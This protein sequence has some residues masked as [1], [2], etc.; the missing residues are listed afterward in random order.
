MGRKDILVSTENDKGK[1]ALHVRTALES[2]GYPKWIF[3]KVK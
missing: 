1:E 2:W 3:D